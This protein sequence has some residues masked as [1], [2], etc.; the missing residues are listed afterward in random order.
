MNHA[1]ILKLLFPLEL[2]GVFDAD[3]AIEGAHL[4]AAAASAGEL[5]KEIYPNSTSRCIADWERVC[6]ITP[7]SSATIAARRDAIIQKLRAKGGQS[8]Q[9]YIDLAAYYGITITID[10]FV[11]SMCGWTR[12]GDRLFGSDIRYVWRVNVTGP[13]RVLYYAHAGS[14]RAGERLLWWQTNSMLENLINALKPAHTYVVFTYSASGT[15]P[16]INMKI[17]AAAGYAFADIGVAGALTN[18]IGGQLFI[19]D[20][21]GKY[22]AGYIKASGTGE[23]YTSNLITNSNFES[24]YSSWWA[25]N[26]ALL[27]VESNGYSGNC[28]KIQEN[29][30]AIPYANYV[31][32][33]GTAPMHGL[34]KW[35]S[36]YVKA[37][38]ANQYKIYDVSN[39]ADGITQLV[40]AGVDWSE[41]TA[42]DTPNPGARRYYTKYYGTGNRLSIVLYVYALSGSG[43]YMYFDELSLVRVLSPAATGVTIV[44]EPN[45][46]TQNWT[47]KSSSFNYADPLGYTYKIVY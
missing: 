2:K 20:S 36:A 7:L 14:S 21:A 38:S 42:W 37:G 32:A 30:V 13:G 4:D 18:Y 29:G 47:G 41:V 26:S 3:I 28:I 45:G 44:S 1:D 43:A 33:E 31:S 40:Q 16:M 22:I 39:S 8:R 24:G 19:Y 10:E 5:L 17:S 23:T 6:G 27:S 25:G 15:V 46:T 12:A 35:V 9:F 11:P 34:Y